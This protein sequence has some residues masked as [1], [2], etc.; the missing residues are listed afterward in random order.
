DFLRFLLTWQRVAADARMQGPDAVDTVAA[1]LEGFEAPAAAWESE[2]L[3]ARL[4]G[5]EP[6]WL[7]DRCLAGQG[8]WMRLQP[9]SP[10]SGNG[11]GSRAGPRRPPP[12]AP[13]GPPPTPP[14]P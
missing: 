6:T 4:A 12:P 3:P 2:I 1:Q 5:Y 10:R 13:P 14:P 11:G 7:D 9:R 8:A